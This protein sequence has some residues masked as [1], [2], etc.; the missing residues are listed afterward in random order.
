MSPWLGVLSLA[1][2]LSCLPSVALPSQPTMALSLS[3]SFSLPPTLVVSVPMNIASAARCRK[4]IIWGMQRW[5]KKSQGTYEWGMWA[6]LSSLSDCVCARLCVCVTVCQHS[7]VH[8]RACP[9]LCS[10]SRLCVCVRARACVCVYACTYVRVGECVPFVCVRMC[11][12]HS[13]SAYCPSDV[14]Y[15]MYK[16]V[17]RAR[18]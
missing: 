10:L 17:A 1:P 13:R 18:G 2:F 6:D 12:G 15:F 4:Y 3:L 9:S 16:R 14:W 5:W 7:T 8:A 11:G